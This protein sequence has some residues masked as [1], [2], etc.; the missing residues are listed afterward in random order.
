MLVLSPRQRY[1]GGMPSGVMM[2]LL[3]QLS[4]QF[5]VAW[6]PFAEDWSE[7]AGEWGLCDFAP[8]LVALRKA[9][10]PLVAEPM[11]VRVM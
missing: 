10:E 11:L 2:R 5:G 9:P 3:F 8:V 7:Q 4:R 1:L 6:V